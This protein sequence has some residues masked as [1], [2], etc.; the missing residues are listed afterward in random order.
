MPLALAVLAVG[1]PTVVIF[2]SGASLGFDALHSAA[3]GAQQEMAI[4]WGGYP[5]EG[6]GAP[7]ARAIFGGSNRWGRLP[8]TLYPLEYTTHMP[9]TDFSMV[10]NETSG[11]VG[12]TYKYYPGPVLYPFGFG[13]SYT[14]FNMSGSCTTSRVFHEEGSGLPCNVTVTNSGGREGDAV[15][16]VYIFPPKGVDPKVIKQLVDFER[17]TI[18]LGGKCTPK[19]L[20]PPH[21]LPS[22]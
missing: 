14:T 9:I 7:L 2:F 5:G 11:N 17:V 16:L 4:I 13:L 18:P 22:S 20:R 19:P 21:A 10:P 12:R 15:V 1:K 8:H 3:L 6:G